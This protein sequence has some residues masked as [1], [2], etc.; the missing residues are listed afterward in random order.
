MLRNYQNI[1]YIL[2][3]QGNRAITFIQNALNHEE[4]NHLRQQWVAL[5]PVM[6]MG[7]CKYMSFEEYCDKATGKNIDTRPAEEIIAELEE[8]HGRKL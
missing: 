3:M 7:Y 4:E 6:Q 8:L 5:L 1:D 2:N